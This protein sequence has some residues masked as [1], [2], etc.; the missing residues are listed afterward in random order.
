MDEGWVVLAMDERNRL[1][2]SKQGLTL[3]IEREKYL[4][5]EFLSS[6][7]GDIIPIR[8]PKN[9]VESGF[10]VAVGDT[11]FILP[12]QNS[13]QLEM[14]CLTVYLN[15]KPVNAPQI[16]EHLTEQLNAIKLPFALKMTYDSCRDDFCHPGRLH[17]AQANYDAAKVVLKSFWQTYHPI[18]RPDLPSF[19]K[20]LAPGIGLA[21]EPLQPLTAKDDFTLHRSQLIAN[22]ILTAWRQDCTSPKERSQAII[23]SFMKHGIDLECPYL[24]PGSQDRYD[25]LS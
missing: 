22:G 25:C 12:T 2:V 1:A 19:T 5:K 9:L 15:F 7:I 20:V 23:E 14:P 10:Y 8:M 17:L 6:S 11:G 4:E 3:W 18:L 16:M 13:T 21:E 24:N